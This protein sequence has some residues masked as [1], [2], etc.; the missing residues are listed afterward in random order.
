MGGAE[1]LCDH[2]Q[3][4][5]ASECEELVDDDNLFNHHGPFAKLDQVL[6]EFVASSYY[7]NKSQ[8]HKFI[9]EYRMI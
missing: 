1:L 4:N 6:A 3:H 5:I 9:L 8:I 7:I 2:A